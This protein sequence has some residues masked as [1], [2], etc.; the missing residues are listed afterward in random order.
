M[1]APW[2]TPSPRIRELIREAAEVVLANAAG[3]QDDLHDASLAGVR[4]SAINDDPVL[5]DGIRTTNLANALHWTV[6]NISRPGERVTFEA[7]SE[8]LGTARDLVRR[9]L[10]QAALDAF[11]TG[12]AIAWQRWMEICFTLT[13]DASEL[14]DLLAITAR[15]MSLFIDDAVDGM[16][17]QMYAEREELERGT[18]AE[19]REAVALILEGAPIPLARAE[20][21]LGYR[22]VGSHLALVVWSHEADAAGHLDA[23]VDEITRGNGS[24]RPLTIVSSAGSRW[25]WLPTTTFDDPTVDDPSRHPYPG[26]RIAVGRPGEG[27]DGFRS[28]H[29]QALTT[30][31]LMSRL[32]ETHHVAHYD[33]IRLVS[34]LTSDPG[35]ADD[36]LTDTL[37]DFADAGDELITTIRTWISLQCNTSRTAEVLY[38][39]RNTVIRRLAR[40]DELLPRPL[41]DNLVDIA[42]AL[43]LLRWR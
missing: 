41:A 6:A 9:G 8:I 28:S 33:E 18:H 38:T 5:A 14:R 24:T 2:P 29:F 27:V 36:F 1:T 7:S 13:D 4:M 19:R 43:E 34:L 20:V 35:A 37:G 26:V 10:D 21:Q 17:A 12:Q 40:A 3:W 11:R 16:S 22:L 23:A 42:A 32:S 25:M 15:S 30:Q 31:R 39:H